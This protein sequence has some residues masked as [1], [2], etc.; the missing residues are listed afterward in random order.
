MPAPSHTSMLPSTQTPSQGSM[1][2]AQFD[3]SQ[4]ADIYLPEAITFWPIAP[5]WWLLLGL[6]VIFLLLI[7]YLIKRK[8]RI[9]EP[10]SKELKSQALTELQAIKKKYNESSVPQE[11]A[12]ETIKELS[13][14]LRRYALSLYHRDDVASLTDQQWLQLLD[15]LIAKKSS[16]STHSD[17]LIADE[18]GPFSN[19]FSTLLTQAPYQPDNEVIDTQL[20]SDL[21]TTSETLVINSFKRFTPSK[22]DLKFEK[23]GSQH[24]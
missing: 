7:I 16:Q 10:T 13:V 5:G 19:Q 3:P 9:P 4:L 12:H 24:V 18:A 2:A 6:I 1:Q 22:S 21:L 8:P 23:V 15:K 14:L 20:L 17:N 11:I